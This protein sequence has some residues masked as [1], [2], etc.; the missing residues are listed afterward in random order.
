MLQLLQVAL[1]LVSLCC[2]IIAVAQDDISVR[3]GPYEV[4]Y[5][6]FNTS[7]L[8]PEVATATGVVR[9]KDRVLVNISIR[10]DKGNTTEAV[11]AHK[12]EGSSFDL[13]HRKTLDF[14]EVVEPGAI[15]YLAEFKLN[16]DNEMVVLDIE[17][18]PNEGDTPIDVSFKRNFFLN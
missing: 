7:F 8:S 15:Y 10:R 3:S 5:S 2:P 11:S 6:A 16:N 13:I 12:I 14:E 9:A 4:F 18:T 17:V 1:M